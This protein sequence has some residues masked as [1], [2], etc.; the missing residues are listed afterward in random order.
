[1]S[2]DLGCRQTF[3]QDRRC[4]GVNWIPFSARCV[5]RYD[6]GL[7]GKQRGQALCRATG[8]GAI[9]AAAGGFRRRFFKRS[10]GKGYGAED[11][12]PVFKLHH[13]PEAKGLSNLYPQTQS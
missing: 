11:I 6:R 3:I 4:L 1:M 12:R 9:S 7:W 13:R 2:E 10:P 5:R 8:R